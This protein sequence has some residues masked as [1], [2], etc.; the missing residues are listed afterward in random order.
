MP[1]RRSELRRA[2]PARSPVD[3]AMAATWRVRVL[4]RFPASASSP[5]WRIRG[6]W[7]R[8]NSRVTRGHLDSF[9]RQPVIHIEFE[10]AIWVHMIPDQR[11]QCSQ[12]S[13]GELVSPLGLRQYLLEHERVD[14]DHAVLK[15][16]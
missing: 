13:W 9:Q 1:E 4:M 5:R 6:S 2:A 10:T 3:R 16:V 8:P 11:R 15:Q 7:G 14:I 12:I